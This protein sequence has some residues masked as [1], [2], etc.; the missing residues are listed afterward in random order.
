MK[1]TLWRRLAEVAALVLLAISLSGCV[2]GST[3]DHAKDQSHTNDKGETVVTREGK[4][5]YYGLL[6][7]TVPADVALSPAYVVGF[8]VYWFMESFL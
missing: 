2:T 5:G 4:P 7:L 3:L 8:L 6:P 1:A